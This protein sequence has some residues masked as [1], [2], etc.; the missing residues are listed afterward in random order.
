MTIGESGAVNSF[1]DNIISAA[2][3]PFVPTNF[4]FIEVGETSC[5]GKLALFSEPFACPLP[6]LI[7][8]LFDFQFPER[9][10][11]PALH[12]LGKSGGQELLGG[13]HA[14]AY[15]TKA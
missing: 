12:M 2:V 14:E 9:P 1:A 7:V 10:S 3:L 5:E 8:F 15:S 13:A 6:A 4:G 11:F